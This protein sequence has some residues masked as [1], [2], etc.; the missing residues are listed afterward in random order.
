MW[1]AGDYVLH[2]ARKL[3]WGVGRV[4]T[5]TP[6][7]VTVIFSDGAKRTFKQPAAVLEPAPPNPAD[8]PVLKDVSHLKAHPAPRLVPV[9]G[10]IQAFFKYFPEGFYGPAYLNDPKQ[11]ERRAKVTTSKLALTLLNEVEWAELIDRTEYT[12]VCARLQKLASKIYM[13]HPVEQARWSAALKSQ[14]LQEPIAKALHT[15]IFGPGNRVNRFA[16]LVQALSMAKGCSI[17]PIATYYGF[18][19]KPARRLFLKPEA[20]KAAAVASG[21]Q[22]NYSSKLN[23][24]TLSSAESMVTY[25]FKELTQ[26]GLKPRDMIDIQSFIWVTNPRYHQ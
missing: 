14:P 26:L 20:T 10:M 11:G 8:H 12:E 6:A 17:W 13:L 23:W 18:L 4:F 21:W 16:G 1:T 19:L 2:S 25:L 7:T 9:S 3:K 22:L 24:V 15:E 5:A